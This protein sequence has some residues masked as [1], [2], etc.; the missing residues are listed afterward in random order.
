ML[1]IQHIL[2]IVISRCIYKVCLVVDTSTVRSNYVTS[3]APN[4]STT[5]YVT[6]MSHRANRNI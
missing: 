5:D 6:T 1:K 4:R 3:P 2:C